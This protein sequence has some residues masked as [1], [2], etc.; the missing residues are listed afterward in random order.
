MVVPPP[1]DPASHWY[2]R[3]ADHVEHGPYEYDE[4]L[5]AERLGRISRQTELRHAQFTNGQWVN[6]DEVLQAWGRRIAIPDVNVNPTPKV[7]RKARRRRKSWLGRHWPAHPGKQIVAL[8]TM[9]WVIGLPICWLLGR[10]AAYAGGEWIA[11]GYIYSID[12]GQILIEANMMPFR[13]LMFILARALL[14]TGVCFVAGLAGTILWFVSP[15]QRR[16]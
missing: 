3:H 16:S 11:G 6:A 7:S 13:V 15:S 4:I 12:N 1:V 8:A 5:A 9:V 2:L 10:H 14:L